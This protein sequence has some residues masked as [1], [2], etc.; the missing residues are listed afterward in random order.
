MSFHYYEKPDEYLDVAVDKD[1]YL[2]PIAC[3]E[4]GDGGQFDGKA[5]GFPPNVNASP[6]DPVYDRATLEKDP[7]YDLATSEKQP[8]VGAVMINPLFKPEVQQPVRRCIAAHPRAAVS[9][10]TSPAAS[11]A[12]V[13]TTAL[14]LDSRQCW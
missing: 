9:P 7:M 4:Q 3:R 1:N 2:Q 11:A 10:A 14:A 6:G 13:A 12:P 5:M 8:A